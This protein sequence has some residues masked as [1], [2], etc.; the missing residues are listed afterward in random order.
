M[1]LIFQLV[2][3]LLHLAALF[4]LELFELFG[5]RISLLRSPGELRFELRSEDLLGQLSMRV[6]PFNLVRSP[7]PILVSELLHPRQINLRRL[8]RQ[9]LRL[10]QHPPSSH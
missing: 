1:T 3:Q 7:W 5:K 2:V 6:R 4:N 8:L 10:Y 9:Q